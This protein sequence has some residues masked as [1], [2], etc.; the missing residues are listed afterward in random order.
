MRFLA[1]NCRHSRL[2]PIG[3]WRGLG[4]AAVALFALTACESPALTGLKESSTPP[5]RPSDPQKAAAFDH[6]VADIR[7]RAAA[8]DANPREFPG[9]FDTAVP[10]RM[11]VRPTRNVAALKAELE[12]IAAARRGANGRKQQELT[13]REA[14]LRRLVQQNQKETAEKIRENSANMQ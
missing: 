7:A 1:Q 6:T 3:G 11:L 8:E 13:A 12:Q 2:R 10:P 4:V 5:K 14:E 9:V